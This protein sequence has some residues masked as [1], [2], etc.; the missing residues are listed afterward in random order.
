M[1]KRSWLAALLAFSLL[2]ATL[3]VGLAQEKEET[4]P[5][6]ITLAQVSAAESSGELDASVTQ[7]PDA[8]STQT[9]PASES[10]LGYA[11][12]ALGVAA[13]T[14]TVKEPG[15]LT[16]ADTVKLQFT[17]SYKGSVTRSYETEQPMSQLTGA[18]PSFDVTLPFFGKWQ[19]VASYWKDGQAVR[20]EETAQIALGVDECNIVAMNATLDMLIEGIKFTAGKD[21]VEQKGM[22]GIDDGIPTIV[23]VNRQKQFDWDRLPTGLYPVPLTTDSQTR[24]GMN[25]SEHMDAMSQ[26]VADLFEINPATVFHFY[27]NDVHLYVLPKLCYKNKLPADQYTLTLVTDGSGTYV[28]FR[29]AYTNQTVYNNT[30]AKDAAELHE[31]YVEKYLAFRQGV[32]DGKAEDY[33]QDYMGGMQYYWVSSPHY[34][35]ARISHYIY[36]ILDAEEKAGCL[37]AEWWVVRR[38][39]DTFGLSERDAEFQARVLADPRITNNYINNCL[40]ALENANKT[41]AFKA[42]YHFDNSAFQQARDEG[43]KPLML[44]GTSAWIESKL[45]PLDYIRM[46]QKFYGDEYAF[47][48]KGHPGNYAMDSE[49]S[50]KPYLDAGVQVLESSIAA[51][52]FAFYDPDLYYAGYSSSFFQN[53]GTERNLALWNWTKEVANEN[54]DVKAYAGKMDF[55]ISELTGAG[56]SSTFL[57]EGAVYETPKR[58][59]SAIL[60]LTAEEAATDRLYLVQ[61][62]NTP[63]HKVAPYDIA[64]WNANKETLRYLTEDQNGSLSF[65]QS[66]DTPS[67]P[68]SAAP[69]VQPSAT[70]ST[71]PST[72]PSVQPSTTPSTQ[73]SAAPSTKPSAVPSTKP[74]NRPGTSHGVSGGSGRPT[75]SSV[76]SASPAP[77]AAP[78]PAPMG[79]VTLV[80]GEDLVV[81][82]EPVA[83]ITDAVPSFFDVNGHWAESAIAAMLRKGIFQ[84]TDQGFQPD[85]SLSRAQLATVLFRLSGATAV[86]VTGSYSDVAAGAWYQ[87]AVN[88]A[89]AAGIVSGIGNNAFDPQGN[90]TREQ[91]AVMLYRYAKAAGLDTEKKADLNGFKDSASV[92]DWAAEGMAWCVS[93]GLL[94][95]N[96]DGTLEPQGNATRAQA[97]AILE[98]LIPKQ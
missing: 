44:L 50:Q 97:A 66:G 33:L 58:L 45:P 92:S 9:P 14:V 63:E 2:L 56:E 30:G 70:P 85:A 76:P 31:L 83:D 74:A 3:P 8:Q 38:S 61:F 60:E 89:S 84:G 94:K 55:F 4:P 15:I 72:A 64:V 68:P 53:V 19:V 71:Q 32:I 34:E 67:A 73:P 82:L 69:S 22:A 59:R 11:Q 51:E 47:F 52:L 79:T 48:Y 98:R 57:G 13:L 62:Q 43:K 20:P 21:A 46:M 75:P 37:K 24:N 49:S 86:K 29:D 12:K 17:M 23:A 93:Q 5:E 88:W 40:S 25:Y 91:M 54:K 80:P 35:Q 90:V 42:L 27:I 28:A 41:E 39:T 65:V 7:A 36:A 18:E 81:K 26:Y 96:P 1:N 77:S 6:D 78:T 95:G 16:A 10:A 87:D